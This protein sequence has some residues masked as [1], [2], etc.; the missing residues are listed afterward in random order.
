M[1]L[2]RSLRFTFALLAMI[3]YTSAAQAA[4]L[5]GIGVVGDGG[6]SSTV[7]GSPPLAMH[8][9]RGLNFGPNMAYDYAYLGATAGSIA[10]N[11]GTLSQL[12]SQVQSHNVTLALMQLGEN[13][14][15]SVRGSIANGT[16]DPS[17]LAFDQDYLEALVEGSVNAVL[18]A[19]GKVILG[20]LSDQAD[21]PGVVTD[22]TQKA[23]LESAISDSNARMAA[24]AASK[25]VPFINFFALEKSVFDSGQFVVGGVNIGLTVGTDPHNFFYD[26]L[27]AGIVI[28]GEVANLWLQAMNE[29]YGTNIPLLSDLEILTRAGLGGEYIPPSTFSTADNL[30]RFVS[31]PEPSTVALLAVGCAALV[32]CRGVRR[33]RRRAA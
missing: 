33:S 28:N 6:E 23:R 10:Q 19:G 4:I 14:L 2:C 31:V 5:D 12:I 30:S 22:A 11:G 25:G 9:L 13:D 7:L 17:T 20:G 32:M 24:F 1:T 8:D 27:H 29:G 16:I 3:G 26:P 15:L 18:A 21:G